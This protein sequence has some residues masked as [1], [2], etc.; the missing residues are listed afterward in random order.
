[1]PQS[2]AA[3][4]VHELQDRL[5]KAKEEAEKRYQECQDLAK[6][7]APAK[8]FDEGHNAAAHER[9]R[10]ETL[11]NKLNTVQ[12][13]LKDLQSA[14]NCPTKE[15]SG[16]DRDQLRRKEREARTEAD[17]LRKSVDRLLRFNDEM[18]HQLTQV[19]EQAN[20][21]GRNA[22]RRRRSGDEGRAERNKSME[23]HLSAVISSLK[24]ELRELAMKHSHLVESEK[25][26]RS[27][28]AEQALTILEEVKK[29]RQQVDSLERAISCLHESS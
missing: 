5:R 21:R 25:G 27:K 29:K 18:V 10:A 8:E 7:C 9:T 11:E 26:S 14:L 6:R 19:T 4:A 24:E 28:K 13:E 22:R 2:V 12:N 3:E 15:S 23:G 16:G 20:R 1:M 17:E